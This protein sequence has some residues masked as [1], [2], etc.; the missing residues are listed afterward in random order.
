MRPAGKT[1]G[2]RKYFYTEL[3]W[4]QFSAN[5]QR[6]LG[7]SFFK[8]KTNCTMKKKNCFSKNILN[9]GEYIIKSKCA[10]EHG[11]HKISQRGRRV[12]QI[13]ILL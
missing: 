1:L 7:K 2:T 3:P 6:I 5:W 4:R 9:F 13:S 11:R 12:V 8:T 10:R